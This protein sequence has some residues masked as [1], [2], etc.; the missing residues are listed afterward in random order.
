M[1][2]FKRIPTK[3]YVLN[4]AFRALRSTVKNS[5]DLF[6]S[7]FELIAAFA[8]IFGFIFI[9]IHFKD[10]KTQ[11]TSLLII[12]I[13]VLVAFTVFLVLRM[14]KLA[15]QT[16]QYD[17]LQNHIRDLEAQ[18]YQSNELTKNIMHAIHNIVHESRSR[19]Q[20]IYD[21][22]I[23]ENYD[24][25]LERQES[26]KKFL[27]YIVT[28]IKEIYDNITNQNCAITIKI[29]EFESCKDDSTD[30][31]K[32]SKP[33][34]K[35]FVSTIY[36]DCISFRHRKKYADDNG[37][38]E[39]SS[40]TAFDIIMSPHNNISYYCSN[41]LQNEHSYVN[42]NRHWKKLYNATLVVPIRTPNF[43][44]GIYN[45]EYDVIGFITVDNLLGGFDD[46]LSYNT[47]ATIADNLYYVFILQADYMELTNLIGGRKK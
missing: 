22:I 9:F 36:R 18:L 17:E 11:Y 14:Y 8:S 47:L 33:Y 5:K 44:K 27:M 46:E 38:F 30:Q 40:N 15:I 23:N 37:H 19:M 39:L 45:G 6:F 31:N 25:T 34:H 42:S 4:I 29:L 13:L 21:D 32:K 2:N 12:V 1:R 43:D 10:V 26:F 24:Q 3:Q 41:D 20:I 16:K 35:F 28:N 7:I